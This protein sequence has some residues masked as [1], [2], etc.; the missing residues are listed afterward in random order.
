MLNQSINI[1][2]I[3]QHFVQ[4]G[5]AFFPDTVYLSH[6]VCFLCCFVTRGWKGSLFVEILSIT[7]FLHI[8]SCQ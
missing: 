1:L 5:G 2:C 4:G 7:K 8:V 6:C 3:L